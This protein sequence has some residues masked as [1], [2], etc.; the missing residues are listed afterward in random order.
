MRSWLLVL[1]VGA[2]MAAA[3]TVTVAATAMANEAGPVAGVFEVRLSQAQSSATVVQYVVGGTAVAGLHY[4]ALPGTVVVP[5]GRTQAEVTVV[6]LFACA[7]DA[8]TVTLAAVSPSP[9]G[10]ATVTILDADCYRVRITATQS[11]SSKSDPAALEGALTVSLS[12]ALGVALRVPLVVGGTARPDVDYA[13]L[14]P[15]V[16]LPAGATEARLVVRALAHG[17]DV[18]A[19]GPATVVVTML[20]TTNV[21]M[22]AADASATVTIIDKTPACTL[23]LRVLAPTTRLGA[24]AAAFEVRLNR[25]AEAAVTVAYAVRGTAVPGRHYVPLEGRLT[26]APGVTRATISVTALEAPCGDGTDIRT[27]EVVLAATGDAQAV[28]LWHDARPCRISVVTASSTAFEVV[29]EEPLSQD[30]TVTLA[31]SA[32]PGDAAEVPEKILIAAGTQR[33]SVPL[34]PRPA[35]PATTQSVTLTL[36]TVN[37][38]TLGVVSGGAAT[39]SFNP[40]RLVSVAALAEASVLRVSLSSPAP[41]PVQVTFAVGGSAVAGLDYVALAA[42]GTIVVPAGARSV[43][44][45]VTALRGCP[46]TA[47]VTMEL[48]AT[49]DYRVARVGN[50][51]S[52]T[53]ALA[54]ALHCVPVARDDVAVVSAAAT[55][56]VGSVVANDAASRFNL[57]G[58]NASPPPANYLVTLVT[59]AAG[60]AL[61]ELQADGTYRFTLN[62][63]LASACPVA[64]SAPRCELNGFLRSCCVLEYRYSLCETASA[65]GA[66]AQAM[67]RVALLQPEVNLFASMSVSPTAARVG[68]VVVVTATL[69]NQGP[70]AATNAAIQLRLAAGLLL[71][72]AGAGVD[73]STLV[74][75]VAAIAPGASVSTTLRALVQPAGPW[76][77][78]MNVTAL[79]QDTT[80]A[81]VLSATVALAGVAPDVAAASTR[82]GST[83][84]FFF[85]R[86]LQHYYSVRGG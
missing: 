3:V 75:R 40:C 68:D 31:R 26:L 15:F 72:G 69:A 45:G 16:D 56:I 28:T 8:N 44:V 46:T 63:P 27:V 19:Q 55:T 76:T 2:N 78:S 5:A 37:Q 32:Q 54:T 84:N 47:L 62:Q 58:A 86:A 64:Q 71:S 74:W 22:V 39:V 14:P 30:V 13:A 38:P 11:T 17:C 83:I 29:V 35:C 6:P 57:A 80:C 59:S 36:V 18:P 66:C 50:A 85:S 25:A 4:E 53:L 23:S 48:L 52:A 20:A 49:A 12:S 61:L 51:A 42:S 33:V 73:P 1:L 65:S 77:A 7:L 67:L 9:S 70:D 60:P 34:L 79:D 43:D 41:E 24:P 82:S 81:G 10:P 21:Q